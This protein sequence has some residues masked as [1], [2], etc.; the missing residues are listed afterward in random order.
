MVPIIKIGRKCKN[1]GIKPWVKY[2]P[3][4]V[5]IIDNIVLIQVCQNEIPINWLF[6]TK[7][8]QHFFFEV[9]CKSCLIGPKVQYE[10]IGVIIIAG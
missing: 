8:L 1:S 10:N 5:H 2:K 6:V 7:L 9:D 3:V 4:A